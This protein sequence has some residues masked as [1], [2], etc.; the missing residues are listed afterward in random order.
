MPEDVRLYVALFAG[1][2]VFALI[3]AFLAPSAVTIA[4]ALLADATGIFFIWLLGQRRLPDGELIVAVGDPF[5]ELV[6]PN[7]DGE[8]V[9]SSALRGQRILFKFFRGSW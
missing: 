3:G 2:T 6:A 9:D 7:Q 5:P 4:L 1:G 8:W